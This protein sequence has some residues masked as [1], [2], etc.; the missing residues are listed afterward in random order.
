MSNSNTAIAVDSISKC[1]RIGL[2]DKVRDSLMGTF[3]DFIRSPLKNFN[4]YRSL[5]NFDDIDANDESP[6]I[7]WALRNVSFELE[8]GGLLGIIGTNGSGKSTLLKVLCRITA[9][10]SGNARIRGRI[11]SLLEV[12]TGF[13][14]ELTGRENIYLNGTILGMRKKEIDRKFDEIVDF[15]GV[16]KFIDTPVKRYSSGMAVRL[17]FAVAAHLDPEILLVDEVLAVGDAEFQM[18]CLGKM[19]NVAKEGR[20]ILFVSHNMGAI[21]ELCD[22]AIWL[23]KGVLKEDGP[24]LS[25]ISSYLAS[26]AQGEGTSW[27]A[28]SSEQK[29]GRMA[30]LKYANI[31]HGNDEDR[32]TVVHFDDQIK[33]EIAYEIKDNIRAFKCYHLLKDGNGNILW[34]SHDTDGN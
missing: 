16:E 27:F 25:V 8:Q 14:P 11:S 3:V 12:G 30:C 34:A 29:S 21:A 23:E 17:A 6:D 20:T 26:G 22:R 15:S 33:V 24:S 5:Y 9:P 7:I 28:D 18:K 19:S 10:T 4:K 13:H 32:S 2:K 31:Y 1:Y